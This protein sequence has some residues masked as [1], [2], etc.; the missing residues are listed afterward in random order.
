MDVAAR[1]ATCGRLSRLCEEG[2]DELGH[3]TMPGGSSGPAQ[4][5]GRGGESAARSQVWQMYPRGAVSRSTLDLTS[6]FAAPCSPAAL[7]L[8]PLPTDTGARRL[9]RPP[10]ARSLFVRQ[11]RVVRWGGRTSPP[12]ATNDCGLFRRAV[13]VRGAARRLA[14]MCADNGSAT[15]QHAV[16]AEETCPSCSGDEGAPEQSQVEVELRDVTL[17]FG[18]QCVLDGVNLTINR[19][20]AVALLGPSGASPVEPG[21]RKGV[22]PQ[23][24]VAAVSPNSPSRFV[25]RGP[26]QG[27]GKS[28]VL[29]LMCGLLLPTSGQVLIRGVPRTCT[30]SERP[31]PVDAAKVAVVFQNPALFDSLSVGE[32]VAFE[33]L[34]QSDLPESRIAE[35]AAVALKRVG[36]RQDVL[37]LFP[38]QLSGGMQKRVSFARAVTYDPDDQSGRCRAPEV[39][40]LVRSCLMSGAGQAAQGFGSATHLASPLCTRYACSDVWSA[41]PAV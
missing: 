32:N 26:R 16:D 12:L 41:S 9:P 2:M 21:R 27:T 30:I 33:L 22:V 39:L 5:P 24:A 3:A 11:S 1:W 19:G 34:E 8:A 14:A 40:L 18:N 36:L 10:V 6:C 37:P 35:L 15:M 20:E 28:S 4:P 17:M 31:T 29:R 25:W 23:A 38:P 13:V 7:V